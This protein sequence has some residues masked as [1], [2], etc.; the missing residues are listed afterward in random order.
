VREGRGVIVKEALRIASCLTPADAIVKEVL[1]W[2]LSLTSHRAKG[3][4]RL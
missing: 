4:E 2:V 1:N 3:Q